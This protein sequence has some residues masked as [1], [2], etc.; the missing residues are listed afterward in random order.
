M[1]CN[2]AYDF[3]LGPSNLAHRLFLT[4]LWYFAKTSIQRVFHPVWPGHDECYRYRFVEWQNV[5]I[6][7]CCCSMCYLH[8]SQS[9]NQSINQKNPWRPGVVRVPRQMLPKSWILKDYHTASIILLHLKN[10]L[11]QHIYDVFR[12]SL[13]LVVRFGTRTCMQLDT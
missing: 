3:V 13:V 10:N 5:H 6:R 1:A 12:W 2:C 4:I 7:V 11:C 9:I 8:C